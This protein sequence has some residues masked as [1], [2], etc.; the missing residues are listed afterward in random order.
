MIPLSLLSPSLLK[1]AGIAAMCAALFFGGCVEGRKQIRAQWNAERLALIQAAQ[2]Q[3]RQNR[4]RERQWQEYSKQAEVQYGQQVVAASKRAG[5]ARERL[6]DSAS[7]RP[8]PVPRVAETP[9][10]CPSCQKCASRTELLGIGEGVVRLAESA[11]RERAGLE[12]CAKAWP[13]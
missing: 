9:G 6:R 4:E 2:E 3:A 12:A 7:R 11:D 8:V 1:F 10:S 5:D 13:G